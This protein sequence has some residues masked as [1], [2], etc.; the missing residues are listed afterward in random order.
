MRCSHTFFVHFVLFVFGFPLFQENPW[1]SIYGVEM[2]SQR[3]S[4][5]VRIMNERRMMETRVTDRNKKRGGVCVLYPCS[6]SKTR[7]RE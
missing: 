7:G 4:V 3:L 1:K 6:M 5:I 2:E